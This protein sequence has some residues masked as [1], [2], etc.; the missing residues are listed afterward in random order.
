M[1]ILKK[2][3]P[4][5]T[6][7]TLTASVTPLL[8]SCGIK[9]KGEFN[10]DVSQYSPTSPYVRETEKHSKVTEPTS[11]E[12]ANTMYF[13]A[14]KNDHQ[15]I[16]DDIFEDLFGE[17]Q[18]SNKRQTAEFKGN[19]GLTVKN[20]EPSNGTTKVYDAGG[21]LIDTIKEHLITFGLY[22]DMSGYMEDHDEESQRHYKVEF[23]IKGQIELTNIPVV[24]NYNQ[25]RFL[26]SRPKCWTIYIGDS[27]GV[28]ESNW[29][30]K[31]KGNASATFN[32]AEFGIDLD[33]TYNND[34]DTKDFA[35]I[36]SI[37]FGTLGNV[38]IR[39]PYLQNV[40]GPNDPVK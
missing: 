27:F 32:G 1:T 17:N 31:G 39:L 26:P 16:Y 24:V 11:R 29:S 21:E 36:W 9:T 8:T 25:Y 14:I 3:L 19:L 40:K 37:L 6:V 2:L 10:K 15:I 23:K 13:D 33:A 5:A 35:F 34:S 38:S 20:V 7:A 18:L 4:I 22:A 30:I 28:A 12:A